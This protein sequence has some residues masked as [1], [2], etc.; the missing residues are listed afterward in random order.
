MKELDTPDKKLNAGHISFGI[1]PLINAVGRLSQ[2]AEAVDLLTHLKDDLATGAAKHLATKNRERQKVQR[3]I[4]KDALEQIEEK[5]L[6]EQPIIILKN[7]NWA[8]GVVGVA[9]G[10]CIE[11]HYRP[12]ILF[13]QDGEELVG[14]ARSISGFSIFDA[15]SSCKK[16]IVKFGGHDMAA[17]LTIKKEDYESFVSDMTSYARTAIT[18]E[19]LIRTVKPDVIADLH[20]I[21]HTT[22]IDIE[23]IGP[24]GMGNPSP[25]VQVMDAKISDLRAMGNKGAHLS[26][27]VG[28]QG[29]RCV[30]WGQGDLVERLASGSSVNLVA[31][32]KANEFRGHRSAELDIV[33]LQ[34]N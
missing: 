16:H 5:N 24:F 30:W 14:S 8:R 21:T 7:E 3:G 12:T 11:T 15:L 1:A 13:A 2:A 26:F 34:I 4:I 25:V 29:T 32:I 10:K 9:A 28:N 27:K 19:Q 22:A 6:D 20:E 18:P 31:K 23:K 17:G 33:D